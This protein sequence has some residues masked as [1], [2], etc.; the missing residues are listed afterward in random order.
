[1]DSSKKRK[2]IEPKP[3]KY[4]LQD[5][6]EPNLYEELFDYD[7][8]CKISF[9]N[10][11]FPM[12]LP[13][14]FWITDTTFRDGQ[15]AR[16]PYTVNQI[17]SIFDM[18]HKLGGPNGVIRQSEFFLYSPTDREAVEKCLERNYR[19]PE[20]TGWIRAVKA[21]FKLVKEIGLKETGILTSASD[22]HIFLKLK[23]SRREAM[24]SY[25]EIVRA[26]L[27]EGIV[28]RC[29]L[30]DITRA[31]F[32]GFIIPF[33]QELMK[34]SAESG[35]P[36]KIRACDT[37]G[38]GVPFVEAALPRSV[39]KLIHGLIYDG[40]VPSEQLEWHGHNDFHKVLVNGTSAWLYGCSAVNGTVLGFGERTGNP[41]IE[42]L[43]IDYISLFGSDNGVDTTVITDVG[44]Y[45]RKEIK[46]QIPDNYPFVG[47]EFN[48]TRAGIHAD[49]V[50]KDERIYNIFNT[51]KLLKRPLGVTITNVSGTAGIAHWVNTTLRLKG[52]ERIDKRNPGIVTLYQWVSEQYNNGRTTGIANEEMVEQ[53][54]TAL[55]EYFA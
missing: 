37:M 48:T 17:V 6:T 28:P 47:A 54:K 20:V 10:V 22:Y 1:M 9:D 45:F 53:A 51:D 3:I 33:V 14:N 44:D 25:L 49:G 24:N 46:A 55:P 12:E 2:L 15:Q 29:H 16:P 38:Y 23:K 19:F 39:P 26:A 27:D 41:P 21:D 4:D 35:I 40:G 50:T 32:Y 43:I 52:E 13:A 34:L 42:G 5:V 11:T 36:I 30:E 31:D 18:L 8:V 7:Q